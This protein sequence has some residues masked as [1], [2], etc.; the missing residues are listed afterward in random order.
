MDEHQDPPESSQ[1]VPKA[2]P[3]RKKGFY[4]KKLTPKAARFAA[5]VFTGKQHREAYQES[6][7]PKTKNTNV[8]DHMAWQ[9]FKSDSV[10]AEMQRLRTKADRYALMPITERLKTLASIIKDETARDADRIYAT[11]AY[12][13]IS[14]DQAPERQEVSGP[15]GKPIEHNV[16]PVLPL[17]RRVS[18]RER[19]EELKAARIARLNGV[20]I[21]GLP[22]SVTQPTSNGSS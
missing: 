3:R 17:I 7:Y 13:K 10:Q 9:V 6:Y 1:I 19:L 20:S 16:T 15:G 8:L 5:L 11:I 2:L 18:H 21:P 22:A 4:P 12:S 14:G